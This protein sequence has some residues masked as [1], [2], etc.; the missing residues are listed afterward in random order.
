[1]SVLI[2]VNKGSGG[3]R[4]I[5]SE[6]SDLAAC[7]GTHF[8]HF[9]VWYADE[10]NSRDNS[11]TVVFV[12]ARVEGRL[13][14]VLPFEQTFERVCGVKVPVLQLF[15]PNEMGVN[16]IFSTID[17]VPHKAKIL[18]A[19]KKVLPFFVWIKWQCVLDGSSAWSLSGTPRL[20]HDSKYLDLSQEGFWDG[21]SKK[22]KK[23]LEK[24]WRKA[25]AEGVVEFEVAAD[26]ESLT[27]AFNE[28]LDVENS[29]WKGDSGT[30]IV[31][32]PKKL[33]FY[34]HL[35]EDFSSRGACR[36][37]ILRIGGVAVAAQFGVKI[38]ASLHLLKIG[39]SES[40]SAV[41]PGHLLLREVVNYGVATEKL[42]TVSFV[43]GVN[44]IDRWKP[45]HRVVGI[46]YTAA[47][48]VLGRLAIALIKW[49]ARLQEK[50]KV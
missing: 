36:V 3:F 1:M 8:L 11:D 20:T 24:K 48:P 7:K 49:R 4:A 44:W 2:E 13:V 40:Y 18:E 42:N 35:Y 43:T 5:E 38:G 16:D 37:N 17:L 39:Y 32:Q 6:W 23:G 25:E 29:G 27:V 50:S 12:S 45:Q 14:A 21:Y 9:P 33:Q 26:A 28:F 47:V 10:L 34:R 19:L 31:K 41:S 46:D 15:Y 30:S 22:F